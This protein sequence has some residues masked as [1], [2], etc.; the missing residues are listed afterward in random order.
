MC[1]NVALIHEDDDGGAVFL[2]LQCSRILVDEA[3]DK[4]ITIRC[5]AVD[6]MLLAIHVTERMQPTMNGALRDDCVRFHRQCHAKG[7]ARFE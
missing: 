4:G 3:S 5:T 1:K 7:V 2:L 6:E